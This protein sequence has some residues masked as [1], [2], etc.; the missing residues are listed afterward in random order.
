M[1]G[2]L[3]VLIK[4]WNN[5]WN[6]TLFFSLLH[7]RTNVNATGGK[8]HHM[9]FTWQRSDGS[10]ALYKD[11]QAKVKRVGLKKGYEL[12][13]G[14]VFVLGQE[15]DSDGGGFQTT[16][17]FISE[18]TNVNVWSRQ[19]SSSCAK[20]NG[21]VMQWSHAVGQQTAGVQEISSDSCV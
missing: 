14:G 2:L 12:K 1:A 6:P 3:T 7:R 20:S 13:S 8:W 17:S 4:S 11:G 10:W 18:M 16:Q 21:D 9:C 15:Q 5:W 19:L